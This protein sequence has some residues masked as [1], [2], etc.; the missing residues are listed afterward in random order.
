MAIQS[1]VAVGFILLSVCIAAGITR[2]RVAGHVGWIIAAALVALGG[3][4]ALWLAQDW[5]GWLTAT[6]FI[7]LIA[8]PLEFLVLA[9]R[10]A[11]S[12][13]WKKAAHLQRWAA[14]LHPSP[15][16]RFGAALSR[17][18]SAEGPSAYAAALA[19]IE[20][21]GAPKQKALARLMLAHERRDW[22]RL[23]ALSHD[24]GL[25]FSDSKTHEIRALGELGCLDEMVQAYEKAAKWLLPPNRRECM[26]FVFAFTGRV[27]PVQQLLDGPL[28]AIDDDSKTY[29]MAVARHRGDHNDE[30]ARSMLRKL[31]E[32][33]TPDRVRR[34][35]AQQL[36]QASQ[37]TSLS[38]SLSE[39][40]ARAV[41]AISPVDRSRVEELQQWAKRT[42]KARLRAALIF[43]LIII[44]WVV[45][46]NYYQRVF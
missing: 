17:A 22:E 32:T 25:P 30:A 38:L 41:D 29:W 24:Q 28:F 46:Q 42:R 36:R 21:T 26:L 18:L 11:Q 20:A 14:L 35:A 34:S 6:L 45:L 33:G 3:V 43:L 39:E 13:Q 16:T 40:S 7:L 37:E 5:A 27:A 12:G 23:L 4:L 19:R 2:Y 44:I 9:R 8:S 10:A 15:W 31:S 1:V